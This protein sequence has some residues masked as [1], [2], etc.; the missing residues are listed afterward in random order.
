[1]DVTATV[2]LSLPRRW[3]GAGRLLVI[4]VVIQLFQMTAAALQILESYRL[5]SWFNGQLHS[6]LS[7][8]RR[9]SVPEHTWGMCLL[10][11]LSAP[12]LENSVNIER[13]LKMIIAHD[14]VEASVEE[15]ERQN[16]K[17]EAEELPW[18]R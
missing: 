18:I 11:C 7:S 17:V 1:M 9:E 14:L 13:A 12:H 16:N 4:A 6:W 2:L 5:I 10:A 15:S 3:L 8:G